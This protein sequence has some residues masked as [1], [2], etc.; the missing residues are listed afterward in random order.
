[1]FTARKNVRF[2]PWLALSA[3]VVLQVAVF[4]HE[5][6]HAADDIPESC[7]ICVQL[8]GSAP[9]ANSAATQPLEAAPAAV[10]TSAVLEPALANRYSDRS[11]RGPP[12]FL[13]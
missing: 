11:A 10:E 9:I 6:A 7:E 5:S 12:L 13:I 3:L 1:M 2:L 4:Q 8:N